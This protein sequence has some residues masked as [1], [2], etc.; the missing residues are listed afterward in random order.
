MINGLSEL[1][2]NSLAQSQYSQL[3]ASFS[4]SVQHQAVSPFGEALM[5][6][7]VSPH[8]SHPPT[9]AVQANSGTS[10]WPDPSPVCRTRTVDTSA[11][12]SLAVM[13]AQVQQGFNWARPI[14]PPQPIPQL[15][16]PSPWLTASLGGTNNRWKQIPDG[17]GAEDVFIAGSPID[18]GVPTPPVLQTLADE[19]PVA[20]T[21]PI[22][23]SQPVPPSS[24]PQ[25]TSKPSL[26]LCEIQEAEAKME[27]AHKASEKE[28]ECTCSNIAT[29][30]VAS[31]SEDTQPFTASWGLLTSQ[32]GGRNTTAP[33][34]PPMPVTPSVPVWMTAAPTATIKKLMKEIQ[35]EEERMKKVVVRE[36]MASAAAC[37]PYAETTFKTVPSAQNT[38]SSAWTTIGENAT[39]APTKPAATPCVEDSP[40]TLSND[41]LK[42]L[43][44]S[45][46]GLN[47]SVNLEEITSML[48]SFL[49]NLDPSTIEIIS[50]LI[51]ANGMILDGHRRNA[52]SIGGNSGKPISITDIV[53]TQPKTVQQE[54]GFKVVN[55]KKK[56]G[57]S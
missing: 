27:E 21:V 16:D 25:V 7:S 56:G 10:P 3:S 36:S 35:E 39:L 52:A 48:F 18:G 23:A 14:Q 46:K 33:K 28:W 34:E 26:S 49:L 1:Q 9:S 15:K 31:S 17:Q 37:W 47:S 42:W 45:L 32:A 11:T 8:V 43:S 50:D 38:C 30:L 2:Y 41:F 40:V 22:P 13:L 24:E 6:P 53:K 51:Y 12:S 19:L 54:W 29:S 5:H 4:P 44:D 57:R 55:K 20:S